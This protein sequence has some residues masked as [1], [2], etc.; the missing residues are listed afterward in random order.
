MLGWRTMHTYAFVPA[1]VGIGVDYR[2]VG[3][4]LFAAYTG[5]RLAAAYSLYMRFDRPAATAVACQAIVLLFVVIV[6]AWWPA[7]TY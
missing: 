2:M 1:L 5:Y 4:V 6:L 3:A 7:Y